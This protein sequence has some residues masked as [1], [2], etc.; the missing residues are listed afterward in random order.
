MC[1]VKT[2]CYWTEQGPVITEITVVSPPLTTQCVCMCTCVCVHVCRA[3]MCVCVC[4][5]RQMKVHLQTLMERSEVEKMTPRERMRL[6]KL[7]A[8]DEKARR[9]RY[10]T[11]THTHT[12][13]HTHTRTQSEPGEHGLLSVLLTWLHQLACRRSDSSLCPPCLQFV[14]CSDH[15][16]LLL[17]PVL[18]ST[19][20]AGLF[21][22]EHVWMSSQLFSY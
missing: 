10:H 2:K 21:P 20:S 1:G 5:R 15:R 12:H 8:A 17:V 9:L 3:C 6:R 22:A 19:G 18:T 4:V 7:Q 14:L 13:A 16:R 11:H